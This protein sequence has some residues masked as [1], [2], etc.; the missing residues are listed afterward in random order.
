MENNHIRFDITCNN[1]TNNIKKSYKSSFKIKTDFDF[2]NTDF[3]EIVIK[4]NSQEI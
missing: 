2:N 1:K 4:Y 3:N